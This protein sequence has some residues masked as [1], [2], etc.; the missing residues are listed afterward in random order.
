MYQIHLPSLANSSSMRPGVG[1]ATPPIRHSVSEKRQAPGAGASARGAHRNELF[2]GGRVNADGLVELG[3]GRI[4]LESDRQALD[5]LARVSAD[6]G[7]ADY[8]IGVLVHHQFH[9]SHFI[10]AA[11]GMFKRTKGGLVDRDV[12]KLLTRFTFGEA[13]GAQVGLAED[14]R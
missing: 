4:T 1:F 5:D 8:P 12:A 7:G 6:H 14:R 11:Q 9:E 13:Y 10:A 2:G 3:L